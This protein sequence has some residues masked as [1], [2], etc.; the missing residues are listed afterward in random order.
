MAM[1]MT[2]KMITTATSAVVEVRTKTAE[3]T[4]SNQ[5]KW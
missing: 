1:V 3:G 4:D 5:L 2:A